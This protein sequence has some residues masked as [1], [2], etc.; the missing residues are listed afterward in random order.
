MQKL[1]DQN[2]YFNATPKMLQNHPLPLNRLADTC[3]NA[4][5]T[6]NIAIDSSQDFHLAKARVLGMFESSNNVLRNDVLD[7]WQ[8]DNARRQLAAQYGQGNFVLSGQKYD[9]AQ[10]TLQPLLTRQSS[11]TYDWWI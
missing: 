5:Q 4:N 3:N 10:R 9:D 1:A 7:G 8:K 2:R 11:T 6:K